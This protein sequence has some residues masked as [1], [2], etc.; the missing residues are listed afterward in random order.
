MKPISVWG[1]LGGHD[2][3]RPK[4][5]FVQEAGGYTLLFFEGH[6]GIFVMTTEN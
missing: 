6:P 1:W 4:G 5:K 3:Q 2:G